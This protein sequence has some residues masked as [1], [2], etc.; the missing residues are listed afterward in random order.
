MSGAEDNVRVFREVEETVLDQEYRRFGLIYRNDE[1]AIPRL[2]RAFGDQVRW[3]IHAPNLGTQTQRQNLMDGKAAGMGHCFR[4]IAREP[5]HTLLLA[6]NRPEVIT[7]EALDLLDWGTSY[8]ELYLDHVGLTKGEKVAAV[9]RESRTIKIRF[10]ERFDPFFFLAQQADEID[11]TTSYY[12]AMPL[13]ELKGE[14]R[15]WSRQRLTAVQRRVDGLPSVRPGD[16][17]HELAAHWA[18]ETIWPELGPET[19]LDGFTLGDFRRVFAGLVVN[20][21]FLAWLEDVEDS[22]KGAVH[23]RPSRVVA[24]P[25]DRMVEWLAEVGG[26]PAAAS[27]EI[28]GALT[29]DTSRWLPS[30]AYQAFVRSKAGRV[31]LLP[32]FIVY[33]DAARTLSQSLNTGGRQKVFESLGGR[34]TDKQLERIAEAFAGRGLDVLADRPLR[35]GGREIRPDLIIYDRACDYLLVADYKSMINPIGPGQAISNMKNIRDYVVKV[36]KY[37]RL[38]MSDLSVLRARFPSLSE[39]PSVSGLLLIRDPTPL[40]LDPDP[41]VA[42]ANWFSLSKF[43]SGEGYVDLPGLVAWVTG[44][45]DLAIRPGSYRLEDFRVSVGQWN[46]VSEKIVREL[47]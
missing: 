9:D 10:R 23:T 41:L 5:E 12:E 37:V 44:R 40:P 27:R 25:H 43:L 19:S 13:E 32:R 17:A 33:S 29:L 11:F 47:T 35:Y 8:H 3:M 7:Q 46:Y 24:L 39:A 30:M 36:R 20:C 2:L 21:A 6:D 22:A 4:W 15:G 34:I 31:Y 1:V 38:V 18:D 45:P 16:R 42:M 28:L 14:F 26:T